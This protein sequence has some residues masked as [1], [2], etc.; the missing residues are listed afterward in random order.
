ML[1]RLQQYSASEA[2]IAASVLVVAVAFNL[3]NLYSGFLVE[4][5]DGTDTV[6]HRLLSE[7]V[8]D[9]ITTGKNFTDP[10]QSSIGMGHPVSHYYQHLP[11][12]TVGLI[13][14]LT[15]QVFP[16]ADIMNWTTY[17]LL[18]AFPLSI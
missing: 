14:V 12:V 8:V 11:H 9:A 7:A 3:I 1:N 15:F 18:S 6:L 10:W 13:H 17:L 2:C 16:V 4:V 5:S